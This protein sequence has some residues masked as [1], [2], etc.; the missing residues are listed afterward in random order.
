MMTT[1][2]PAAHVVLEVRKRDGGSWDVFATMPDGKAGYISAWAGALKRENVA[3]LK[4]F[5]ALYPEGLTTILELKDAVHETRDEFRCLTSH[6]TRREGDPL[7][8][9]VPDNTAHSG[10]WCDRCAR[11][12][13]SEVA[14]RMS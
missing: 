6:T 14:A 7:A 12:L 13:P 3:W 5:Q 2:T 9:L 1:E 8:A 11:A 4:L 10:G